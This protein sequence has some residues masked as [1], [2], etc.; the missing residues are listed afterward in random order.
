MKSKGK[1]PHNAL[2][3]VKVR[4]SPD[5]GRYADGNGLYLVVDPSGAKRWLLR[6]IIHGR[7]GDMGLG[8]VQLVPLAEAREKAQH[9][10]K[11]AREGGDPIVEIRKSRVVVPTFAEAVQAVHAEH[12]Q[13]WKNKKHGAQWINTLTEYAVATIGG[14]RVDDLTTP[15]ILMFSRRFG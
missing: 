11:I 9:Y 6:T 13:T 3:S 7:R 2:T 15:D 8:G 10:R 12:L 1:H 4:Q 5:Q 14:K